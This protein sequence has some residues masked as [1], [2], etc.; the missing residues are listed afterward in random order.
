MTTKMKFKIKVGFFSGIFFTLFMSAI[1]YFRG[2]E[3]SWVTAVMLF[4]LSAVLFGATAK[5]K[6]V[7]DSKN[8]GA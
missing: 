5:E 7:K 8:I 3:F 4:M 6:K 1:D 2:N